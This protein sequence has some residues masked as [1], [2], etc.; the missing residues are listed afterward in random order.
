MTNS[1]DTF[2]AIAT[3]TFTD[4]EVAIEN[5]WDL[6]RDAFGRR[7]RHMDFDAMT[8]AELDAEVERCSSALEARLE[9]EREDA[10]PD[11]W[12]KYV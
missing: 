10:D 6:H 11:A 3:R 9:D 2:R 5:I 12:K 4:R 7:P 1:N 8:Q